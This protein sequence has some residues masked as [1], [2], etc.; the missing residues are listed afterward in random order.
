[1]HNILY[2][3]CVHGFI[4]SC[5]PIWLTGIYFVVHIVSAITQTWLDWLCSYLVK[6]QY[7]M[8]KMCVWTYRV[9]WSNMAYWWPF[10]FF[11]H[12]FSHNSD[13]A[14]L[15]VL[16]LCT[17]IIQYDWYVYTDLLCHVII[18]VCLVAILLFHKLSVID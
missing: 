4:L 16:L 2:L 9:M 12:I 18:C 8:K 1:M 14:W 17:S 11:S 15:I 13:M 7:N 5:D 10:S 3:E 6:A